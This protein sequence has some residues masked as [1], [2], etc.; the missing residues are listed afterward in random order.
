MKILGEEITKDFVLVTAIFIGMLLYAI[1]IFGVMGWLIN[2]FTQLEK[3]TLMD[4]KKLSILNFLLG[5]LTI[6]SFLIVI[7]FYHN[8]RS[9]IIIPIISTVLLVIL[10]IQS[11]RLGLTL[12][13]EEKENMKKTQPNKAGDNEW[14]E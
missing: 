2:L 3:G 7:L 4:L 13:K 5:N 12:M 1:F 10:F 8:Y 6:M 9:L 11:N 14:T